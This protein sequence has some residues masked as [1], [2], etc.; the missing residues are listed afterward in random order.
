MVCLGGVSDGALSNGAYGTTNT[1]RRNIP[2]D[3]EMLL[4]KLGI[5]ELLDFSLG[6]DRRW[7]VRYRQT[8]SETYGELYPISF[9]LRCKLTA[10]PNNRDF[11]ISTDGTG[12]GI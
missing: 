4:E 1:G 6:S 2:D 10:S 8:G 11:S 3:L 12:S 7:Y 9:N 5:D